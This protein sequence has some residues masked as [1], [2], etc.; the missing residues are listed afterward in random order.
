MRRPLILLFSAIA[1]P[2][3]AQ[4]PAAKGVYRL[5]YPDG[6]QVNIGNDHTTHSPTRNRLDMSASTAGQTIVAAAAGVVRIVVDDNNTVCLPTPSSSLLAFDQDDDDSISDFELL[7]A[8]NASSSN[9]TTI[10]NAFTARCNAF[11][12]SSARCCIRSVEDPLPQNCAWMGA[13][14]GTTCG[15]GTDGNGPNNYIWIEHPNG[16]WTKYTHIQTNSA[17]VSEGQNIVAGT[18]LGIE[19]DV[20][21]ATGRHVHFEVA[22]IESADE[23]GAQGWL[24]D[25]DNVG[26][27]NLRNRVPTFCQVGVVEQGQSETAAK[28]DDLCGNASESVSGATTS[29]NS[30]RLVQA[31]NTVTSTSTVGANSGLALRA[32]QKITLQ[33]GF[34]ATNGGFFAAEIGACDAPG[35]TGDG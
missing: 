2:V 18:P 15:A 31:T 12:T 9:R 33:P 23:I 35:G 26:N 1:L 30:P 10:Q 28:C 8:Y 27:R 34:S 20:G 19:G 25:V 24:N 22:G 5:P 7:A 17:L 11:S 13:P 21:I 14:A 4:T 3:A 16:E 6:T 32:G 29:G